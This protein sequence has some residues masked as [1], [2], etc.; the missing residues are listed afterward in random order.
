[1]DYFSGK[2]REVRLYSRAI[3]DEEAKILAEHQPKG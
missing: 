3:N 2:I 1:M